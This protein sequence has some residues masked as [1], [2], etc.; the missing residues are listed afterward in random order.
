MS[1]AQAQQGRGGTGGGTGGG[2]GGGGETETA[3][4]NLSYPAV[5]TAEASTVRVWNV[6]A[7]VLGVN[8]SFGCARP[9]T[10]GTTT[11]PNTSCVDDAG[12]ALT[13]EA[14]TAPPAGKCAGNSLD[15]I[16]WQK[17][18]ANDWWAQSSGPLSPVDTHY[19]DWSDGLESVTWK[20]S[21]IIRVETTPF[22]QFMG[23]SLEGYEMWHVFGQGTNE[24]WGVRATDADTPLPF[25]YQSPYGIIHTPAARLNIAK[26]N[27]S[28]ACPVGGPPAGSG[29]TLNWTGS[30]WSGPG[31]ALQLRD[32][33]YVAELN[34]GG[35]YVYGYN[36]QLRRDTIEPVSKAGWWRLTF[37]T[38]DNSATFL[39]TTQVFPPPATAAPPPFAL[40]RP[41]AMGV[42]P[43]AD[44]GALYQPAV[45][46]A[47]NLTYLDICVTEGTGSGGG[48][49]GKGGS[50]G[51]E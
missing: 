46:T 22:T 8:Y 47:Y 50:G 9:E 11:Y 44:T 28:L 51:G 13:A 38:T 23:P 5:H 10:I 1:L 37:Y 3:T 17:V 16:Y 32:I 31:L 14:C 2:K 26:L 42:L 27:T 40:P 45:D 43:A 49:G 19:V 36:W 4:N 25:V 12:N 24:Q 21:S 6:P 33:P 35:K 48:G 15:R 41:I 30:S 39:S 34:V 18:A 20:T 29:V 7:G